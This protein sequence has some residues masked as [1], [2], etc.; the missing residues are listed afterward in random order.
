[1]HFFSSLPNTP[2]R[3]NTKLLKTLLVMKLMLFYIAL[4]C[5]QSTAMVKAQSITIA[6]E[7]A[8]MV[9]VMKQVEQQSSYIFIYK[10]ALIRQSRT[11]TLNLQGQ[12][13]TT[14]LEKLF[15][16]QPITYEIAGRNIILKPKTPPTKP[17]GAAPQKRI[18]GKIIDANG[19]PMA[20]VNI[21][22]KGTARTT[23]SDDQGNYTIDANEGQVLLATFLGY[24]PQEITIGNQSELNFK[25]REGIGQLQQV[26]VVNTGF[27]SIP[28]ERSTGSFVQLNNELVDRRVSTGIID[29]LEGIT[30]SLVFNKNMSANEINASPITIRG[31]STIFANAKPL[32]VVDNFPF[33]GDINNLNPNDVESITIL[34]D[35]AAA[36]IWGARSGN[37]VII[38]TTKK[39]KANEAL[40]IN[41]NGN[42][43]YGEKANIFYGKEFLNTG[44][45]INSEQ[46]LFSK[47]YYDANLNS[48]TT[49]PVISPVVEILARQ[50]SGSITAAQAEM[51]LSQ[52]KGLDVRDDISRYLY[53]STGTQQ[54]SINL[55]GGSKQSSYYLSAGYDDA[56][57]TVKGNSY[58]RLSLNSNAVYTPIK[59][60][61]FSIG[62]NY[63]LNKSSN[64]GTSFLNPGS[65]RTYYYPYA[66]LTDGN[67]NAIALPKD[68][69]FN[70]I[71]SLGTS[72]LLDWKFKPLE[73]L[74]YADNTSKSNYAR[75]NAGLK[76]SIIDGLNIEAKY[77][78]EKQNL[79]SRNNLKQESYFTRNLINL[80]TQVSGTTIT[81]PIPLG[82][83]LDQGRDELTGNSFRTQLNL[84]KTIKTNHEINAIAGIDMKE[85]IVDQNNWRLYGYSDEIG[86]S[87]PVDYNSTFTK[88]AS[89]AT[90]GKI[91]YMDKSDKATDIFMSYFANA[92]YTYLGRYT[93]SASGRIDQSN[94]FGVNTNQKSVPLWSVGAAWQLSKEGFFK[95]EI[96]PFLK[97]R[98]TYGY[99]G[100]I[101]KSVSAYTTASFSSDGF[102]G[103]PAVTIQNPPNPELRWERIGM[104][105]AGVDFVIKGNVLSGSIE[106]YHKTGKDMIGF[107][108]VDPTTG[109]TQFKGNVA[110]IKGNGIDVELNTS[111]GNK[112]KWNGSLIYSY[113][114][115][116]VTAYNRTTVLGSYLS[117]NDGRRGTLNITPV[118]GRPVYSVFSYAWAGLD[119]TNG[120]PQGYL[121][122]V[123]S[124][125]Y[126]A[127][128]NQ[129]DINTATF[130]GSARPT[131]FG[132]FRNAI[133][134]QG[135]TL[136]VNLT[137]KFGYYF[138]RPTINYGELAANWIGIADYANRWQNA[139][140]EAKTAVPSFTY[141]L[142]A[143][144]D[145]F[146]QLSAVNVEKGDHIRLQD[147]QLAYKFPMDRVKLPL[148]SL[149]LY[150]YANNLGVLWKAS[151]QDIDPDFIRNT[152]V[153]PRTYSLGVRGTF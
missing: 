7:N 60:M 91:P 23:I 64:N 115:D 77:Q 90:V 51:E 36:S 119:P 33:D 43:T 134:Y 103:Y 30:N 75:I 153:N 101:D 38:I 42:Y 48:N 8:P 108:P 76:Y 126:T 148:S 136:S 97:L 79:I 22:V 152:Y 143:N 55:S 109:V 118:V 39:G 68:Y 17:A 27:Q 47:G 37:G 80:N 87:V 4:T 44:D 86:T 61:E 74:N 95:S 106:Y 145:N 15:S 111:L 69:R 67:G 125:D 89:L 146:Y 85:L 138:R 151:K 113:A 147:V 129:R 2:G 110:E 92:A 45:F 131:S 94:L 133:T 25:L 99:N 121:N 50:R 130:H 24:D 142:N 72:Q 102:T 53:Q 31:Q 128:G 10:D 127:I 19:Q 144:R 41:V 114:M 104:F 3:W 21:S 57:S 137:Y 88:Y 93:V 5:F 73:E 149:Q 59:R 18:K 135:V 11:V 63:T 54:Y 116:K 62:I 140:D 132:A 16:N 9:T 13:L 150:A 29:R 34:R 100:N 120:D 122:G 66:Q 58:N 123:V 20:G 65:S 112:V 49:R 139:G 70:Y 52:F 35:A 32:I 141:P 46:F 96:L 71:S 78:F 117:T 107:A 14:V 28:K 84:N 83:I 6:V 26:N 40:K 56:P 81:R 98:A 12:P 82:G 124:K 1:M 105:N